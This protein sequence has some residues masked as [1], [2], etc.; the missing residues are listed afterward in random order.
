[1]IGITERGDAALDL[2]W[3]RWV[4]KG[5]P[6]ILITKA[7]SR[8]LDEVTP[9]MNVIVHCTITGYGGTV[10]EPQVQ[11]ATIEAAAYLALSNKLCR[12]RVILRID[13]IIPYEPWLDMSRTVLYYAKGR[14]RVSFLDIYPHAKQRM[15]AAGISLPYDDFHAPLEYRERAWELMGRPEICGEPGM[16][17]T[18]CVSQKD[19]EVL[20]LDP[21]AMGRP[22][23][24][25]RKACACLAVKKELLNRKEPCG[26]GCLYCYWKGGTLNDDRTR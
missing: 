7:P 11:G 9:D 25:Q 23:G 5:K 16:E 19:L 2:S 4:A 26:H 3:K 8:L 20:N 18:G 6:A 24:F 13:P 22:G 17:C 14:V 15:A 1:M 12:D 10:L 21:V